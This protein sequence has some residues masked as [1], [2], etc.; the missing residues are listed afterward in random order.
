M[1]DKSKFFCIAV[2]GGTT[3]GR[4]I[5][6]NWIDEMATGYNPATYTARLNCEHL[7]GFSPEPPF[8]AYGSVLALEARD[9][10]LQLNGKPEKRRGLF[11]QIEPNDQLI[12]VNKRAQKLFT[13]CEISPNFG[14]SGKAGL[15]GLAITDSPASLGT[16]MLQF[17]AT[18]GDNNPL[19]GRK[20]DK[21]NLFTAAS[22]AKIEVEDAG[23]TA[24]ADPTTGAFSAMAAFFT[25]LTGATATP[26]AAAPTAPV[27]VSTA[28][29]PGN[30]DAAAQLREGLSLMSASITAIGAKIDSEVGTIRTELGTLKTKLETTE[31]PGFSRKPAPG[32]DGN[33]RILTD[34]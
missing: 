15:V 31:A 16:E 10:E 17:A 4:V 19:A 8:N 3:D 9:V 14:G 5:E 29:A 24:A 28:A 33:A 6:R 18:Q 13:S 22:E 32:G 26:A 12:A 2:E 20:Q 21:A 1:A 7:R 23:T 25:K 30:D 27:V 11:A 34:C